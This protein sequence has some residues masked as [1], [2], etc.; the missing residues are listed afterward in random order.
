MK[1]GFLK[2]TQKTLISTLIAII[3]LTSTGLSYLF[4]PQ[5]EAFAAWFDDNWYY[6]TPI[7]IT[8][9]AEVSNN[10]VKFVVTYTDDSD[11][12]ID[13]YINGVLRG[14]STNGNGAP[15][16]DTGNL[17]IGGNGSGA[18]NTRAFDG[19]I[20]DFKV[21]NYALTANQVKILYNSSALRFGP[22][23]GIP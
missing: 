7:T 15:A 10:K 22:S 3:T 12:E 21:Y 14:S 5:K 8:H 17:F 6:R 13:V 4:W 11:D 18:S 19:Q 2:L 23:I 9:N 16:A 20:D 1:N